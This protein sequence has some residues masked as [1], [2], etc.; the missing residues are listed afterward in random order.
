M[1][2]G[3][4]LLDQSYLEFDVIVVMLNEKK[5]KDALKPAMVKK[6]TGQNALFITAIKKPKIT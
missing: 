4:A 1:Y 2:Y 5:D 6:T 3:E